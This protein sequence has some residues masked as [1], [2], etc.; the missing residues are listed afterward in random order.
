MIRIG[1]SN[2]VPVKL[3]GDGIVATQNNEQLFDDN[4]DNYFNGIEKFKF[5]SSIYGHKSVKSQLIQE[6]HGKCC[7]CESKITS[8]SFGDVEHFRPKGGYQQRKNDK[9]SKP[10]YYW[11]AYNWGNLFFS[12]QICN[13]RFKKNY[14]PLENETVRAR[15]HHDDIGNEKPQFIHP[16]IDNPEDHIGFHKRSE[17]P[18]PK[19][20]KGRKSIIGFGLKRER[21]NEVRR[22]YLHH[23]KTNLLLS[24][25]DIDQLSEASK[26]EILLTWNFNEYELRKGITDSKKFISIATSEKGKFL[27]MIKSNFP[28]LFNN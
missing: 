23:F 28:E 4:P 22:E 19:D 18:F 6:Q 20:I 12:C 2:N 21:L 5:R 27:N 11:F 10:G 9:V 7:F 16:S 13:Q 8:T 24:K 1:K 3:S 26:N 25:I 15:T 17:V 14:F